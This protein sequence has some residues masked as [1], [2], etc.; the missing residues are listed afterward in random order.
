MADTPLNPDD[1]PI[2]EALRA[3]KVPEDMAYTA[4]QRIRE[5]AAANLIAQLMGKFDAQTAEL[6]ALK[7]QMRRERAMLWALIALIGA[8]VLRYLLGV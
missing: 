5:L 1:K 4:V 2:Y 6:A 3:A 8:A 7:D